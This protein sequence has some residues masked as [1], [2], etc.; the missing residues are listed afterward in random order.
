MWLPLV[1][2]ALAG[3]WWR[4]DNLN[5][6]KSQPRTQLAVMRHSHTWVMAFLYIG[7]FGSFIGYSAAMPLLIKTQFGGYDP[8][9]Y[10]FLGPL[11]GS[12]AR[13]FGGWLSDRVGGARVTVAVFFGMSLIVPGVIASLHA[14]AFAPFLA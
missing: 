8:L 1:A 12:I 10:A 9:T 3:A 13:P 5:T 11:V 7:A 6:G 4:M 2:L 14:G